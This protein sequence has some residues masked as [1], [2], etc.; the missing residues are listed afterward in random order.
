[1]IMSKIEESTNSQSFCTQIH[2][3]RFNSTETIMYKI[4]KVFKK[5]VFL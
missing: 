1:M 4:M 2:P 3:C 5:K